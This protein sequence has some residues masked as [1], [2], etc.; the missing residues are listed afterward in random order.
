MSYRHHSIQ[1]LQRGF[2]DAI[3]YVKVD[4]EARQNYLT[5]MKLQELSIYGF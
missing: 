5:L 4:C 1:D 2:L 3:N